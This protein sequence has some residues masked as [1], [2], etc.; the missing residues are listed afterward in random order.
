VCSS[1]LGIELALSVLIGLFAGRW[2]DGKLGTSPWLMT[3]LLCCG[4]AAGLRSIVRTMDKASASADSA[5]DAAP[6]GGDRPG[7]G[8][9]A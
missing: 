6:H 3:V 2:L 4:F 9:A 7:P 8:S 5:S 1:D